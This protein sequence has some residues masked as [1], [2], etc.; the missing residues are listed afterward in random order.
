[1]QSSK[2]RPFSIHSLLI[3]FVLYILYAE[4]DTPAQCYNTSVIGLV[5]ESDQ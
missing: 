3:N 2:I 4:T 1:M 5:T